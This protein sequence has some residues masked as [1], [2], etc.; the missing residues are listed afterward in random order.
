[1]APARLTADMTDVDDLDDEPLRLPPAPTPPARAPLPVVTAIVPVVGALVLWRVT[2][3]AHA[4]WF[5]ALGPLVAV[6]SFVDGLRTT[7]RVRRR[8]RRE[9]L[10]L[11]AHLD[12]A[13]DRRHDAERRGAWRRTPDVATLCADEAEVWRS[14]PGREEVLVVGRGEGPSSLRI[15]GEPAD[16]AAREV[17]R[18]ARRLD[19]APVTVP[20][21]AGLAVRGPLTQTTA[22]VRGLVMQICL[23]HAPGRVRIVD[24]DAVEAI[25]GHVPLPHAFASAGDAL[26][27]VEGAARVPSDAQIPIVVVAGDAPP[28]PRCRAVLT[29]VG[30][31]EA[32][33]DHEGSTR[34]VRI[35]A[36]SAVQAAEVAAMLSERARELGHRGDAPV[37]FEELVGGRAGPGLSAAIGV[38]AG[39]IVTVDL[40][41][42]GPHAVVV[43][44][45]GSGK[46]ELLVTWA[47]GLCRGRDVGEVC[48]LLIDFKGG[49]T[50]DALTVLPHVTGV[51]TDLDD[52]AAVRAVESLRA[53]I[54]RRER[55]LAAHDARDVD[56]AP[57]AL[58]RLVVIVDEF[59]ALV[60]AHPEMHEL[61]SDVAARGRALGIHT[62]LASQRAAGAFRDGLLAN[63][64]LRI[65][66]RTLDAADSRA[67]IG[68]DD[69]VRLSG[70][71][72]ARG[73]ALVRRA[74]DVDPQRV[75]MARCSPVAL[76][77]IRDAAGDER[78]TAPWLRPLPLAVEL[79]RVAVTG[80][81]ALGLSDEPQRQRQA[82]V[83]LPRAATAL[84]VIGA[85][86]S[87]RSSLL[88]AVARQLPHAP[89][90]V[91]GDPEAAWDA[92]AAAV[93]RRAGT[94]VVVDDLDALLA[95]YPTDYTAEMMS[96]IERLVRDAGQTGGLVVLSAARCAGPLARLLDLVPHRAILS[97]ATRADHVAAGGE[98]ADH[99]RDQPP[100]RGRWGRL[101]VQFLHD[102]ARATPP[103][104]AS[105]PPTWNPG[106]AGP[107]G[108][109]VAPGFARDA[110][111]RASVERDVPIVGVA[112]AAT[113]SATGGRAL[114][115]GTPE[116]WLAHWKLLGEL[117]TRHE[118]VVAAEC[119]AD[120][121]A[122]TGRRDLPV[123]AAAGA[124][125]AW[126]LAPDGVAQ[127]V[128]LPRP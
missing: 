38:S 128:L 84:A 46:S 60:G 64:P 42:D 124:D 8:A 115:V 111:N 10:R 50:F 78:A 98:G 33:L 126:R 16:D 82:P 37:G 9:H 103:G 119:I 105:P 44:M 85:P 11:L 53:E 72:D 34:T 75:R 73:T 93:D 83:L 76:A 120:Y 65:A 106:E 68:A 94:G 70:R 51:V 121:R 91:P 18:R 86:G 122:L 95:R 80:R 123:Y 66:L 6:A 127:R 117:R 7:R 22:V 67:V 89:T 23:V 79:D 99:D 15:E 21:R 87:G 69:A 58:P 96:R 49:R 26:V 110:L 24:L 71:A 1:M 109:V 107:A 61:F 20:L 104:Y 74:A 52:R 114:V 31:D 32:V 116:E 63:A 56:E 5:A 30:G 118:L 3:S 43:G 12:E 97:L 2:G 36:L 77:A 4:L 108:L 59:A 88:R 39:E 125:R 92:V 27:V 29:L 100:G 57:G 13:V 35:E 47:A 54:R 41:A 113:C 101:L 45:T 14:V 81:I 17:R 55:V 90:W 112:D 48:L 19:D 40:V 25:V 102:G 62:I 28:P